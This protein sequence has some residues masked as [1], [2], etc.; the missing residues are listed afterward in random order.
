MNLFA[1][2]PPKI[3]N[4]GM[5]WIYVVTVFTKLTLTYVDAG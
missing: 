4:R 5:I 2:D 1:E 3:V